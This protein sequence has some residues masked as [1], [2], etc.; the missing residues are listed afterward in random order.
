MVGSAFLVTPFFLA[1]QL[2]VFC[3]AAAYQLTE[4]QH[5][6]AIRKQT[7]MRSISLF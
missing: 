4:S 3:R 7:V 2:P 1:F 5:C 6:Q